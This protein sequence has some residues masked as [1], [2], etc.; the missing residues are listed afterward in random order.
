MARTEAHHNL[1]EEAW[2]ARAKGSLASAWAPERSEW[3]LWTGVPLALA[4]ILLFTGIVYPDVYASHFLPEG[5]GILELLHFILPLVAGLICIR[6]LFH[7]A[8]RANGI[9]KLM[10]VLFALACIY[11]A[12][13]EHSWG[14]HFFGWSTP[15]GWS[16]INRQQET[17]LHNT[18]GIF[19][20]LPQKILEF[21]ILIGGIILPL[22]NHYRGPIPNWFLKLYVPSLAV[23]P[24]ALTAVAFKVIKWIWSHNLFGFLIIARP[25]EAL[26]T[27]YYLFIL[28]Y[29]VIY[30]R[31]IRALDA[32]LAD[33]AG[34]TA[35]A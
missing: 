12:G 31:R 6:L 24:V 10:T 2:L 13:E 14:Q 26:E 25:S 16:A 33:A 11:I 27:F 32:T 19:N 17:N 8:V 20:H 15:E 3:L 4:A 18:L 21:G 22:W 28:F 23:L 35:K 29:V 30:A 9:I 5:F 7:P 1:D 34:T